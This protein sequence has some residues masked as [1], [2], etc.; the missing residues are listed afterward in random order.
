VDAGCPLQRL[1]DKFMRLSQD[2]QSWSQKRIGH[3]NQQIQLARELLHQLE[4]AQDSRLLSPHED[5]LRRRL[6]GHVLGL[7]SLERT[8]A[9]LPRLHWLKE[10]DANTAYF[11]HHAC[12]R[13]KKNFMA[14]VKVGDRVI[15]EQEEKKEALGFLQRPVGTCTAARFHC[16]PAELP[17]LGG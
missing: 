9:R 5:W 3:I 14:K 11:H 16:G 4:I 1:A 10:G 15:T 2:L 17:S 13:K 12:Y 6:K 8:I 7:S